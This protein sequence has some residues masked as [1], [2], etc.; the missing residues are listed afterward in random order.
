M[1]EPSHIT[2]FGDF[3]KVNE[4]SA[5]SFRSKIRNSTFFHA[6]NKWLGLTFLKR[7]MFFCSPRSGRM[8][9]RNLVEIGRDQKIG[10]RDV[11]YPTVGFAEIRRMVDFASVLNFESLKSGN[12]L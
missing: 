3:L 2:V 7:K 12:F 1:A 10:T 8:K 9:K 4:N 6:K 5:K 11:T